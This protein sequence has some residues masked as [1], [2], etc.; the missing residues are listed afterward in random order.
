MNVDRGV[1][2]AYKQLQDAYLEKHDTPLDQK[3]RRMLLRATY[4]ASACLAIMVVVV[5]VHVGMQ[6]HVLLQLF[7][8]A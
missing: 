1:P 5:H 7:H 4:G 6:G 2:I 3:V 8:S